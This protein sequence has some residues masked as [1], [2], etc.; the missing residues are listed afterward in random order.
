MTD[1]ELMRHALS[2]SLKY[3]YTAKPN[4]TVGA[5][6]YDGNKIVAEGA[7]EQYGSK[8]AEINCLDALAQ[9]KS[10]LNLSDLT[11]Y[12]TLE[13]CNHTGKTGP[14]TEAI[15]KSGI[16]NVVI[17]CIDPNPIVA[18][19][20]IKKL[21]Q[22]GIN[23]S[24]GVIEDEIKTSSKF[25]FK[26]EQKRPFICIKIAASKDGKSHKNYQFEW[27]TSEGS[28]ADVQEL[29][30]EFDCILTGG[31]TVRADN[32]R[33][34]ARVPFNVN[35]P[36]RILFSKKNNW[37]RELNF[38]A[39]DNFEIIDAADVGELIHKINQ[40]DICSILVEAGPDLVNALIKEN[41]CDEL[42]VYEAQKVLGDEYT[43]WFEDKLFL[44]KNG[45]QLKS[46]YTIGSDIKRV[47]KKC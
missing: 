19:K 8:H 26:H 17:G 21:T 4:P 9:E 23:V 42:I 2:L 12:C 40:Q 44:D 47:Y 15:I 22:T 29:R 16:K 10:K 46:D 39:N 14:C 3:K 32:P 36:K 33:M 34:N 38:F 37:N 5:L 18:G 27:I 43:S 35:Q 41:L 7:H 31:N 6:I 20:G 28:R 1:I 30:A 24:V 25:F 45:F 11:L 13:P